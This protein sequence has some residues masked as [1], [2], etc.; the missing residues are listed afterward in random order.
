MR[1]AS[2]KPSKLRRL[3]NEKRTQ[4][5]I[6]L[7]L[8]L[9]TNS[10]IS[11]NIRMW[12][13][14]KTVTPHRF[15]IR[16]RLSIREYLIANYC[17]TKTLLESTVICFYLNT[18]AFSLYF[19]FSSISLIVRWLIITRLQGPCTQECQPCENLR[20]VKTRNAYASSIILG[21]LCLVYIS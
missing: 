15:E 9:R 21:G 16:V 1:S 17:K 2:S 13:T 20:K 11:A 5:K 14:G 3:F 6:Q 4:K 7:T 18:S 10:V 8:P 19:P 12:N